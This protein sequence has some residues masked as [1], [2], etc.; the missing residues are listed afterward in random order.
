ME[1]GGAG[2]STEDLV[3]SAIQESAAVASLRYLNSSTGS[4][5]QQ[6]MSSQRP[7]AAKPRN[8]FLEEEED[9][10]SKS[11]IGDASAT[12][13][14]FQQQLQQNAQQSQL[15]KQQESKVSVHK[16]AEYLLTNKFYLTALEYHAE[17]CERGEPQVPRLANFFSNPGNFESTYWPALD[18]HAGGHGSGRMQRSPSVTTFDSMDAA[19]NSD[20]GDQ[21]TDERVPV[22]EFELR[23][24]RETIASLRQELT[25]KAKSLLQPHRL[26]E[27]DPDAASAAATGGAAG[28]AVVGGA[29]EGDETD[30]ER[31]A[32]SSANEPIQSHEKRVLNFLIYE[33]L[34]Q[35]DYK[36]TPASF[37]EEN[38]DQIFDSWDDVGL[39]MPKPKDLLRMLRSQESASAAAASAAATAALQTA[40]AECQT[41]P[42]EQRL[43]WE[44]ERV[45]L[46]ERT[47]ELEELVD[48]LKAESAASK[49]R[50]LKLENDL[51]RARS[52]MVSTKSKRS[53]TAGTANSDG[54]GSA[55]INREVD[56]LMEDEEPSFTATSR[57]VPQLFIRQLYQSVLPFRLEESLVTMG[58]S[59][60]ELVRILGHVLPCL[61]PGVLFDYRH[62]AV[63][64]AVHTACLHPDSGARDQLL[65]LLFN[66]TKT[67][68]RKQRNEILE[69]CL[70]FAKSVGPSR[71]EAELLPQIWEQLGHKADSRRLL[72]VEACATLLPF[73]P[74][75][76]RDS[77]VL[78][79][80]QQM[81]EEERTAEVRCAII[82]TLS[83]LSCYIED[84][85][86]FPAIAKILI[87]CLTDGT[88][89]SISET[90]ADFLLPAVASWALELGC[91]HTGLIDPMLD[92]LDS[93]LRQ[94]PSVSEA[95]QLSRLLQLLR[96]LVPFVVVWIV[97]HLPQ[98]SG[99]GQ[100]QQQQ[101]KNL[102][103]SAVEQSAV[104][105]SNGESNSISGG[106]ASSAVVASANQSRPN[107][108]AYDL[109][110]PSFALYSQAL[111]CY[112]SQPA[113]EAW[114]EAAYINARLAPGL[115]TVLQCQHINEVHCSAVCR[116]F[117]QLSASLGV[118][119]VQ[120]TLMPLMR[121]QLYDLTTSQ[122]RLDALETCLPAGYCVC[123]LAACSEDETDTYE[124]ELRDEVH[125]VLLDGV[126]ALANSK[127]RLNGIC[128]CLKELCSCLPSGSGERAALRL[129]WDCIV[130]PEATVELR[131]ACCR[132]CNA[133][134][135]STENEATIGETVK[136][137]V[138]LASDSSSA[139]RRACVKPLGSI[140]TL[141]KSAELLDK[142]R[143][144]TSEIL[145][146]PGPDDDMESR[147]ECANYCTAF[148]PKVDQRFREDVL[149]PALD[150]LTVGCPTS[151]A[152]QKLLLSLFEAYSALSCSYLSAGAAENKLL[153]G[154]K[155]LADKLISHPDHRTVIDAIV[156]DFEA[157]LQVSMQ[158]AEQ[159]QQPQQQQQQ[160]ANEAT[161]SSGLVDRLKDFRDSKNSRSLF[162]RKK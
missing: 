138:T 121:R 100:Q 10:D 105:S 45:E 60:E 47:E 99:Y 5:N 21:A 38:A 137:L 148:G 153:P 15:Q 54:S 44:R 6:S 107:L 24:A 26:S 119:F 103:R 111:H 109:I 91:L 160:Q 136:A 92:R 34:L 96:L 50:M 143:V 104:S 97:R 135:H 40:E 17:L 116:L 11:D 25:N 1:A 78:S 149:L 13:V 42:D 64:L 19:R 3:D 159:Q 53:D 12:H 67:P 110:C 56:E 68:D 106:A 81:F 123:L 16:F 41:D 48:Q 70:S 51:H 150:R 122:L 58:T 115:L 114:S 7:K 147:I 52:N 29:N 85:D 80:L 14:Q 71:I 98:S 84:R 158:P 134:V 161:K 37:A 87:A 152:G 36:Y 83:L 31:Q 61:I 95:L 59:P 82:R 72:V 141:A 30:S 20:N 46:R 145:F 154:L 32:S 55:S 79:M 18:S 102:F 128:A 162:G 89:E 139:V 66:M 94:L 131:S 133:L 113:W 65:R 126:A 142:V 127:R 117:A 73:L 22:L 74:A 93:S 77:L 75:T 57:S 43:A 156:Q 28:G 88:S 155:Q 86:K 125:K 124:A 101:Q 35:M 146:D 140:L 33:Y 63:P 49:Q 144:Q 132:L 2:S 108:Y 112:C 4:T 120:R 129:L 8:P 157:R 9:F 76:L 118:Y 130:L 90:T 39:N 27:E 23:K 151:A 69:G 62:L